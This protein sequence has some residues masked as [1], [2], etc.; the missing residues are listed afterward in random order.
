MQATLKS[1][2]IDMEV[3]PKVSTERLDTFGNVKFPIYSPAELRAVACRRCGESTP[4]DK[5]ISKEK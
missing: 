2:R 1:M 3:N 4:K 5:T